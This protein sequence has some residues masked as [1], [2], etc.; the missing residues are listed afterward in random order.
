MKM[1]PQDVETVL[2]ALLLKDL[3]IQCRA[4]NLSPAGGKEALIDRLKNVMIESGDYTLKTAEGS[5][6]K[7]LT[8]NI[9]G[10]AAMRDYHSVNN[11]HRS[12]GQN[13]GNFITDRPT[14]RVLAPP[15]GG[16]QVSLSMDA[17]P[18]PAPQ[19][20]P[21]EPEAPPRRV[22]PPARATAKPAGS[23]TPPPAPAT[24]PPAVAAAP[25]AAAPAAVAPEAKADPIAGDPA[26]VKT[27][28]YA[29][30]DGMQNVGNFITERSSSRVIA[31]PGGTSNV[32]LG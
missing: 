28:N 21:V 23:A 18:A 9:M 3:R 11:Y 7:A 25:A 10:K 13:V 8:E 2:K 15:G 4:R 16:S 12:E 20:V 19:K 27:N 32:M 5:V 24:P 6:D 14:S 22:T 26:A 30:P 29:R 31:P 1:K 17:S